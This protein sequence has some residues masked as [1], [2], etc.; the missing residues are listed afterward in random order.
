VRHAVGEWL[1][2]V[3]DDCIP[4]GTWLEE[5]ARVIPAS[6]MIE[7]KTVCLSKTNHPLGEIVENLTADLFWSCNLA[8]RRLTFF[9]GRS[10][11]KGSSPNHDSPI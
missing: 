9:I 2:F 3:D 11:S 4:N 10:A 8:I 7:G 6:N 1:A 5:I